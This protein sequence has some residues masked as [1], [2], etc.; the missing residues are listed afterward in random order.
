[1]SN[2]GWGGVET[3]FPLSFLDKLEPPL[4]LQ[5]KKKKKRKKE[6]KKRM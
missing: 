1:M 2:L 5:K 4:L 3:M 6:K